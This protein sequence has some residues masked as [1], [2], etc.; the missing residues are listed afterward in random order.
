MGDY[1]D[2]TI[3][4][5][6]PLIAKPTLKPQ[7]LQKPPFRFLHDIV[8]ALM[9]STG[10]P[11]GLFP[12]AEL[13]T[14]FVKAMDKDQKL[15]FLARLL[16]A[17]QIAVGREVDVSPSK[18]IAGLEPE[19]TNSLLVALAEAGH[20]AASLNMADI[21]AATD[22]GDKPQAQRAAP[23]AAA[24]APAPVAAPVAAPAPAPVAKPR[25]AP[26]AAPAASSSGGPRPS[27]APIELPGPA[28]D[29][30][31]VGVTTRL[32]G[33]LIQKPKMTDKLLRKPPFRFL[34]DILTGVLAATGFPDAYFS[35]QELDSGS[36][37]DTAAKLSFL[38][39]L[40]DIVGATT[41]ADLSQ[42]N[43]KKIAAGLEPELT[44]LLLQQLAYAAASGIAATD[45]AAKMASGGAVAAAPA[46]R[47]T[48]AEEAA[49]AEAAAAAE[50]KAKAAAEA[51]ARKA[52]ALAASQAQQQAAA[53]AKP[54]PKLGLS[55]LESD[56]SK[57]EDAS[58]AAAGGR[59]NKIERPK[60]ARKAP[61][62]LASNLIE[63]KKKSQAE[64]EKKSLVND[65]GVALI[66]EGEN[67]A[68]EGDD[69]DDD[70]ED[71]TDLMGGDALA[72]FDA[73]DGGADDGMVVKAMKDKLKGLSDGGGMKI[74]S[75]ATIS[76]GMSQAQ[77]DEL[78][79]QIQTLC[80]S[81]NPLG[82]CID[83]VREDVDAMNKELTR[84]RA[85]YTE[86]TEELETERKSTERIVEPLQN[87]LQEVEAQIAEQQR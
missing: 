25:P 34:H 28:G 17:V 32:I 13:D 14:E 56:E 15:A 65:S 49:A 30:D 45:A 36:F 9:A 43:P 23:P 58:A 2:V 73:A 7:L 59:T 50:R 66:A 5:L 82:K 74:R 38:Q 63:E 62:K 42:V 16:T 4:Q 68:D 70:A 85:A 6:Q 27:R 71:R 79:R 29:E 48:R 78:R 53:A 37:A 33:S 52:A 39:R 41:G 87:Q 46:P 26:A 84:W 86:Y 1:W 81:V 31:F 80:Q 75:S 40:I 3:A 44:N 19:K 64:D 47:D 61:P 22:R 55:G 8:T 54:M 72:G 67:Q 83:F 10:F 20:N 21:I 69:D 51:E 77:L 24:A 57:E 18:I 12:Q 60:T 76:G 35:P 11:T